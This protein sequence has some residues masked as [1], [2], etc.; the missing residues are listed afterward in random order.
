MKKKISMGALV[1]VAFLL[2]ACST[3]GDD[4][5]VIVENVAPTIAPADG[6]ENATPTIAPADGE[7][8]KEILDSVPESEEKNQIYSEIYEQVIKEKEGEGFLFSLIY[9]DDDEPPE[10]VIC[11]RGYGTYSVYTVKD[12]AAFCMIDSMTTVEMSYF[13]RRGIVSCFARW[14]G[15]GDEGG[16]S[17]SY[18]QVAEDK[19]LV[20]GD[21]P[22]LHDSYDAV[23]DE[24]GNWTG[25]GITKYYHMDQEVDEASYQK[26]LDDLGIAEENRKSCA[27]HAYGK[28]E[29]LDQMGLTAYREIDGA[30]DP[31][32]MPEEEMLALLGER[33]EYYRKSAYYSEM[34]DYWENVREVRDIDNHLLSELDAMA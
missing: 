15:G 14:N 23:Y 12:G 34:T 33:M 6:E 16:Y 1:V 3:Q 9:L 32:D 10:L 5:T 20:D 31:A 28:E 22:V 18:Y 13:E 7:E 8:E 4:G 11:D 21:A 26:L 17:W 29:I 25:E 2:S 24:E 19:A 30:I 27:D